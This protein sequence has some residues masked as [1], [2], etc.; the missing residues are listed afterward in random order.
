MSSQPLSPL[1]TRHR[2]RPNIVAD[3]PLISVVIPCRNERQFI[4]KCLDSILASNYPQDRLEV[5]VVDGMSDDGTSVALSEYAAKYDFI[6]VLA[7]PRRIT[8]VAFNIGIEHARGDLVMIMSAHATYDREAIRKC[9]EYSRRYGAENVGGIWNIESRENTI[10][11]RAIVAV[12]SHRFGVGGALYRTTRD[13]TPRWVDTAAYGCYRREVFQKIGNYNEQLVHSQDI[14]LNLRLKN[15]GGR[16]LLAPDVVINYSARSDVRSFCKHNFRN[17]AWAIL[18]FA[19]STVMPVRWRHLVPL[20]FLTSLILS[21]TLGTFSKMFFGMFLA[22][23]FAY[24]FANLAASVH[25]AY[26]RR[27]ARLLIVLPVI[28]SML[29]FAYGLGSLW[30]CA[31]LTSMRKWRKLFV[32]G[33]RQAIAPR[34]VVEGGPL[35]PPIG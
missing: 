17:G 28:F 13:S 32:L 29:H 4:A 25:I 23:A 2:P 18:P 19:Y 9:V 22:I 27:D 30:A 31:K 10:V 16:T 6:R 5:L 21:A 14:E 3:A 12:L 34:S 15:A 20:A 8:P 11:G 7:N 1:Q 35:E 26:Q 33:W 24:A